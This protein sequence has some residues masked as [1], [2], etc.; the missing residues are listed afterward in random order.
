MVVVAIVV[1]LYF[2]MGCKTVCSKKIEKLHASGDDL[3]PPGYG[4]CSEGHYCTLKL[5]GTPGGCCLKSS[6]FCPSGVYEGT[7]IG[8]CQPY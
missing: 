6:R 5:K 1:A 8:V 4:Y 7:D 2:F 3:C